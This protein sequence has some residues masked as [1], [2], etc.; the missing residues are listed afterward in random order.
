MTWKWKTLVVR[1]SVSDER[2]NQGDY[3]RNQDKNLSREEDKLDPD[4][5]E[6]E[7]ESRQETATEMEELVL[8]E[9][10]FLGLVAGGDIGSG[11][12]KMP[13]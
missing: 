2:C 8:L 5:F 10:E 12:I 4:I 7:N 6:H 9:P 11:L 3:S 13:K 1:P